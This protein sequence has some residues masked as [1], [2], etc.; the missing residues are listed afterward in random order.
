M[1]A[2]QHRVA[3]SGLALLLSGALLAACNGSSNDA[4]AV[5]TP[6]QREHAS[7]SFTVDEAALP[8]EALAGATAYHGVYEG[9]HGNAGYR[10]E[11]PDNWNGIL[12][13]YA[14]GYRGTGETLTVSNPALREHLIANGYAW[15]ASSYSANYYDVRAGVEDT[16]ALA[17]AFP[18]LT[19]RNAPARYYITGHSM[20]GHITGAAIEAEAAATAMSKVQYNGAV[21]MCGVM[22]DIELYN[23]FL[24]YNYAAHQLA[25]IP[26]QSFPIENHEALL[27]DIKA[28]LW[29]DY[30]TDKSAMTTQGEKLKGILMNLSG[31][32]RPIFEEG[33][34]IYQNLLLG[35]GT[36][37]GTWIGMTVD[38]IVNTTGIE[39]Q[40]DADPTLS[41]AEQTFNSSIYRVQGD[42]Q[43]A[44]PVRDDGVR[45][46]PV[47]NGEFSIPVVSIHTLGDLFVPFKMQ[48]IYAQRA[49]A[50]GSDQWLVQ[51]AIRATSHCRFELAEEISA[52]DAMVNWE[53]NG[54]KPAGD[55]VL[56]PAVVADP[57][58]G[59]THTTAD[60]AGLPACPAT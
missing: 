16:N 40:F 51:R 36:R 26:A 42:M 53:Q 30:D 4:P 59:C 17:L 22:G 47:V 6:E 5:V 34:P 13:M 45:W 35:Y 48:Q 60:R 23:Y 10:I 33:F 58:Y 37:D 32:A 27:P 7:R 49:A 2:N 1:K 25:G 20:G 38:N 14:H 43:A 9:I 8:F 50:N 46:I 39:F 55:N 24:A 29:T 52:F 12:V 44:N 56:D 41:A 28:A 57:E 11:V 3:T 18:E 21:P 54:V 31:G 19:N 15:A